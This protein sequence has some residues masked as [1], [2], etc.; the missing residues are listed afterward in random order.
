ME[1]YDEAANVLKQCLDEATH[2]YGLYHI[3]TAAAA[4][5][6]G[7]TLS[8]INLYNNLDA[9]QFMQQGLLIRQ[10]VMGSDDLSVANSM[11]HLGTNEFFFYILGRHHIILCFL[12]LSNIFIYF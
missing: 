8:K 10:Q 4:D 12:L 5:E 7:M 3:E 11:H 6:L 1:R 9:F 2:V